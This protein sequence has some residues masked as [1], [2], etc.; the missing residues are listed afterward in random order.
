MT[1]APV[2]PRTAARAEA[3]RS[4]CALPIAAVHGSLVGRPAGVVRDVVMEP[5]GRHAAVWVVGAIERWD[6]D[7]LEC[8]GRWPLPRKLDLY[9][10]VCFGE[11]PA[12]LRFISGWERW[13]G[14]EPAAELSVVAS[15]GDLHFLSTDAA[16]HPVLSMID[17]ETPVLVR[18]DDGVPF[19]DLPKDVRHWC[20]ADGRWVVM[21]RSRTAF[22]VFEVV[23][24]DRTPRLVA[25]LSVAS[26]HTG[27]ARVV[28][29]GPGRRV[30]LL[31][32]STVVIGAWTRWVSARTA[33]LP[34]LAWGHVAFCCD[35]RA[36]ILCAQGLVVRLDTRKGRTRETRFDAGN[37][38]C[39]DID[40]ATG[41]VLHADAA[42]LRVIDGDLV[43]ARVE[44]QGTLVRAMAA[45]SEALVTS[46]S[47]GSIWVRDRTTGAVR[48]RWQCPTRELHSVVVASGQV[49]AAGV[50]DGVLRWSL[51]TG[52]PCP[53]TA[54]RKTSEYAP[55]RLLPTPDGRHLALVRCDAG[56]DGADVV[57]VDL[58]T[59][60]ARVIERI[61][62]NHGRTGALCLGFDADATRLRGATL[63]DYT[64]RIEL[65]SRPLAGG[66]RA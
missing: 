53:R 59:G 12:G 26:G 25:A 40:A 7:A 57:L 1:R 62:L 66:P 21:E 63:A 24:G 38:G 54:L 41:R 50:A 34:G 8:V 64:R 45:T 11:A 22:E 14:L 29:D 65:W 33:P 5:G 2:D 49:V 39:F 3:L 56:R 31:F 42:G 52:E 28:V 58:V 30:A 19:C 15:N 48:A 32:E 23:A 18:I 47:D 6:L 61:D 20:D 43:R 60:R 16:R 35:G 13:R 51:R 55:P 44:D 17:G 9:G 4:A 10:A 46:G 36:L 37:R 27:E